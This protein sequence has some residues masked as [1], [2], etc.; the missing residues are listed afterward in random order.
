MRKA[1][2]ASYPGWKPNLATLAACLEY[3]KGKGRIEGAA[4]LIELLKFKGCMPTEV[5][6]RVVKYMESSN[7]ESESL[8][9]MGG[10]KKVLEGEETG[11][12]LKC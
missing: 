6:D 9:P 1:I 7:L 4:E 5:Y 3:L 11:K 10:S 8:E 2:L 12:E